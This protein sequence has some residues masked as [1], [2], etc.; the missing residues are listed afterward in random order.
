MTA[1]ADRSR[2]SKPAGAR[3]ILAVLVLLGVLAAVVWSLLMSEPA[4]AE[5][6]TVLTAG[7]GGSVTAA[8]HGLPGRC[9][10]RD[11]AHR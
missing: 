9:E 8:R 3:K 11:G 1:P 10:Q 2:R 5:A 6:E 7:S 4:Q